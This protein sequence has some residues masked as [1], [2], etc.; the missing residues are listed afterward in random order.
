MVKERF[1]IGSLLLVVVHDGVV[2]VVV[3]LAAGVLAA[4]VLRLAGIEALAA[5]GIGLLVELLGEL[6]EGL[7]QRLGR[8]LDGGGVGAGEGALA[9]TGCSSLTGS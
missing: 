3:V 7:R 4:V 8:A 5:L 1:S 2:G 9:K 6:V